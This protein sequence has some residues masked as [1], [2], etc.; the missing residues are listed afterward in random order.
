MEP[1]Y[2][3]QAFSFPMP[4][5]QPIIENSAQSLLTQPLHI[6]AGRQHRKPSSTC[7]DSWTAESRNRQLKQNKN[8]NFK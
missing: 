3:K 5:L 1:T 2:S 6:L 8:G 7:E 4:P